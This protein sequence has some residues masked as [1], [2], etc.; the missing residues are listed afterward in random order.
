MAKLYPVELVL[1]IYDYRLWYFL[2]GYTG[3]EVFN[4]GYI[5]SM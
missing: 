1:N 4:E 5:R 2:P 3:Y